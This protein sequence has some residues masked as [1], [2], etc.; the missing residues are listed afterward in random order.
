MIR[1]LSLCLLLVA[2]SWADAGPQPFSLQS[3]EEIRARHLGRPVL[4]ML[5]SVECGYCKVDMRRAAAQRQ[6]QPELQLV[7]INVDA[8]AVGD[9]LGETI[10]ET[11]SAAAEH[12]QFGDHP[13]ARL[14]ASIDPHW[15]GELPRSYL[16]DADG[17]A[18]GRSGR[19][20][21]A[22]LERWRQISVP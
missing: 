20:P 12:W 16:I 9:A 3:F 14:R 22:A 19:L 2:A 5:W 13:P 1:A 21:D 10:Q 8:A 18:E 15:Y 11:G 4:V 6:S 17:H 7:M